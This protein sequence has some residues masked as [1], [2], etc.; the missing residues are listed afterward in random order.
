MI[1]EAVIIQQPYSGQYAE[2][3]YDVAS[4]WNSQKWTWIKFSKEDLNEWCGEFRGAPRDV[5]ISKKHRTIL[6]LTSDYLYQ[7]NGISGELI[8]YEEAHQYRCLTVTPGGD[9]IIADH[10]N[11]EL[12]ESSLSEKRDIKSPIQMDMIEFH[13]WTKNM[14]SIICDEFLNWNR[15][16]RLELD[17]ET[18]EIN[19]I[20]DL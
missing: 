17:G 8:E 5:V 6:V 4:P 9:F 3:I 14:L 2:R 15:H 20:E 16:I 19:V 18:L 10:S 11:I 1:I 12:I 7:L 13:G